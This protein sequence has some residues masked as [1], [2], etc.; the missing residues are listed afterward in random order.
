[1]LVEELEK[2]RESIFSLEME[3]LRAAIRGEA[4]PD[5]FPHELV[6]KC[7][8][9]GIRYHDG[10]AI[11]L[12]GKSLHRSLERAFN[13]RDIMSNRIPE[14]EKPE[15][16]P[17]CFWHPD[18]PSQETLRHLLNDHPTL[19]MRY[20]IGRACAAGGYVELYKELDLLPDVSIAEEAHD[21]L[22]ASKGIYDMVMGTRNLY[23]VMDDYNLCLFDE[24]QAGAFLNGDTCVRSTLDKRQPVH[25]EIF[26]PPF[27]ITE[28]WCLAADGK[29]LEE[30]AIPS[31]TLALLYAPLPRHLP[32][33]H[34]D[35][36]ILMAAF[37]G[38]IDRYDRLRR[39][40]PI[41]G[42]MQCIVRGIYHNTFF[43]KWCYEQPELAVLQKFAHARFIMNDDLTWLNND[44]A[45]SK[46]DVPRII[47]YPQTANRTTY[48]ELL[49]LIPELK[50][51][52]AQALVVSDS[53]SE[54]AR[55][56]PEITPEIYGEIM[57]EAR[58]DAFQEFL[59]QRL[60]NEEE[61]ELDEWME[62]PHD[63]H[64]VAPYDHLVSKEMKP[65]FAKALKE[66]TLDDVGFE[67]REVYEPDTRNAR[68]LM[69]YMSAFPKQPRDHY[70]E[71]RVAR[72]R[73]VTGGT[74]KHLES[75]TT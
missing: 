64:D 71:E 52:V 61:E 56:E 7:L 50:Q 36:L 14:M 22:P 34:K 6:Y 2:L 55:L 16:T 21:N 32:T 63:I 20:K 12:R 15:D 41:N 72:M 17:Y 53:P 28:D 42:E 67:N 60:S 74:R 13:A 49:R 27:D 68:D 45:F 73:T 58:S 70:R 19:F 44:R 11:E 35:I 25:H 26:P 59:H 62:L 4:V 43:A 33:V 1:M 65:W 46:E 40:R 30:R 69:R 54:F 3:P 37:T 29:R 5:D 8:V 47:W 38:N 31:D 18:V 23:R 75:E 66:L 48:L 57:S 24:P 51:L 39:P 10:F 9:A